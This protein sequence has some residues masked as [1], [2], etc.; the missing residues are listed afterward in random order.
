MTYSIVALDSLTGELGVAVQSRYFAVGAAVPWASPGVGAV[1]TQAMV[2]I[3]HG[4]RALELLQAGLD[5]QVVVDRLIDADEGA[6]HRQLAVVDAVGN[7]AVH[8]GS[9]CIREAGHL[10]RNG[11]SCQ[12]NMLASDRVWPAMADAFESAS[13][14]LHHRLLAALDAAEAQGGDVRGRQSAAILVVPA[15]GERWDST[16][17][18]RIDDH[19]EPLQELRRLITL[20]DA[21]RFATEANE[22][23]DAGDHA[24]AARLFDRACELAPD[25]DDLLFRAGVSFARMGDLDAGVERVRAAIEMQPNWAKML[26]RLPTEIAPV[27][28]RLIARLNG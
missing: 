8:T 1:A 15:T 3:S 11:F 17:S 23:L 13:G 21:Y 24:N 16:I 2:R 20:R 25:S 10:A 9:S 18:V 19:P 26:D 7:A 22:R 5:A 14:A 6:A 12:G 4:P 27:A 28:A